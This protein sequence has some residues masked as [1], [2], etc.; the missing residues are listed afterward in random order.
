MTIPTG[1]RPIH[2]LLT[3]RGWCHPEGTRYH[4]TTRVARNVSA[5]SST[6]PESS[7]NT[8]M[9]SDFPTKYTCELTYVK[10]PSSEDEFRIRTTAD[11]ITV[12][13]PISNAPYLYASSF[14]SYFAA[15]E[16]VEKH[17]NTYEAK[18]S[19]IPELQ[20]THISSSSTS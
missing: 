7:T 15:T 12:A 20:S 16:F 5:N 17:L 13:V 18:I 14:K 8:H 4:I 2:E 19:Q 11:K 1:L 3:S 9:S 6:Q 10:D